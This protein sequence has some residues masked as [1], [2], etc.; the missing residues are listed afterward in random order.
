MAVC[1]VAVCVPLPQTDLQVHVLPSLVLKLLASQST[2]NYFSG[3]ME[4]YGML[5]T[6]Y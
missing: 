4:Y 6:I 3:L 2:D 1:V 5:E